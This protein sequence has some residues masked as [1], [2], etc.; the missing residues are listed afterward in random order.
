MSL[1][2]RY[3]TR[4]LPPYSYVPGLFPHP[5][6]DPAG[7]SF[8]QHDLP[9]APLDEHSWRENET[10]HWAIDLFNHGYYWEA[11]EAW[12]SLWHAAGRHGPTAEFLKGLIKLAAAGVK[13]REGRAAGVQLHAARAAQLLASSGASTMFGV[14]VEQLVD[15][16]KGLQSEPQVVVNSSHVSDLRVLQVAIRLGET[17]SKTCP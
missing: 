9:P 14:N 7:H 5:Q 11:H 16:A 6:S 13:A 12:E 1:L 8:G 10:W 17:E 2:P 4:P 15:L 3:T